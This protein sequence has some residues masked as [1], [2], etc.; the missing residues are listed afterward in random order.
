MVDNINFNYV[1]ADMD[2][3]LPTLGT[4]LKKMQATTQPVREMAPL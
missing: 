3:G 1:P 2:K 4:M